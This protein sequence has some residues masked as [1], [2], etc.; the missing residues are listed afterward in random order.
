MSKARQKGTVGEIYNIGGYDTHT[1]G[2]ALDLLIK[3][4]E[5][6]SSF[7]KRIDSERVRPTDITLQ[8]PDSRKF[9]DDTG[10]KP[11]KGLNDIVIDL[12]DYWR[13]TL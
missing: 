11:E 7:Q 9:R 1:I 8:I 2:E 4:S 3:N 5:N 10:W 13:E 12:L 6:P